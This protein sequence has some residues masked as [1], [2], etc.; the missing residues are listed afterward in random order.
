MNNNKKTVKSITLGCRFNFYESELSKAL[1]K[2]LEPN[3]DVII[4]N[5]CA[6]TKQAENQS[7]QAVRKAIRESNGA[8]VIVT[9]CAL[10]TCKDYFNN[11]DGVYSVIDN[12]KKDKILSY[13][14]IPHSNDITSLDV[15]FDAIYNTNITEDMFNERVRLFLQIQTGCNNFCSYCIVP[16]ARGKSISLPLDVILNKIK[17][18]INNG[19]KEI[20]LS[21]IDITSYNIDGIELH[22]VVKTIL[23]E[24]PTLERLRISSM[25]PNR[26]SD[27]LF[28]LITSE[29]RILPHLHLSIQSGN[30]EVLKS[31]RRNYTREFV[32]DLINRLKSSKK[33][34]VIGADIIAGYPIE[35]D[36]C[37]NSTVEFIK[38][39]GIDLLHVFPFSPRP[40]TLASKMLQIP[41]NIVKERASILRALGNNIKINLLNSLINTRLNGLIEKC[42]DNISYG[43]TDNYLEFIIQKPIEINTIVKNMLVIGIKDNKLLCSID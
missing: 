36:E 33:N 30:N 15:D 21:G 37:F 19:F 1:I 29:S 34:L 20:V 35:T 9:G 42:E 38:V 40:M 4:I 11:L 13:T 7:K 43:K 28:D 18:F 3:D 16:F 26:I 39:S 10:A 23:K 32:L 6:V 27:E 2:S 22:D 17:L 24:C 25:N 41:R 31:M 12:N 14:S 8:K 5:T